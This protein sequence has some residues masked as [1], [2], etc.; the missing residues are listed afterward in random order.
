MEGVLKRAAMSNKTVLITTL[1]EAWAEPNS[2]FDLF[3]ESFRIGNQ[4][5]WLL[6]H[7]VVA[8][9]DQKAYA[10]CLE[11]HPNCY[12]LK[13]DGVDFSVEAHFMSPGYLKMMW[14]RIDFL[15]IVLDMGYNFIF[16]VHIVPSSPFKECGYFF[17]I[18]MLL[19]DG[20]SFEN[21][22]IRILFLIR[23]LNRY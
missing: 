4:T 22:N 6:K 20:V 9:L 11:L 15:R 12:F 18:N 17:L 5:L 7:L 19:E 23:G 14:R 3:L 10:R 13:T 8:A 2:V 21:T 1:N 16:T